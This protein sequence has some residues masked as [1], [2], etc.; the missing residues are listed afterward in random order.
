MFRAQLPRSVL[1]ELY[2]LRNNVAMNIMRTKVGLVEC[3]DYNNVKNAVRTSL[4]LIGGLH[5]FINQKSKILVKPNLCDP[6]PPEK[7]I[8]GHT[9]IP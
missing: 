4:E 1:R 6:L 8:V 5:R 9:A 3:S 7:E 2:I